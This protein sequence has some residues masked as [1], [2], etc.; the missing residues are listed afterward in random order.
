MQVYTKYLE[1]IYLKNLA[2]SSDF[3]FKT[4]ID[5]RSF[6]VYMVNTILV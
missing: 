5:L 1:T 3:S 6:H 2:E 4:W